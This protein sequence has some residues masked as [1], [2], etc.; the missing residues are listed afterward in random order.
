MDRSIHNTY[1]AILVPL[2]LVLLGTNQTR[3]LGVVLRAPRILIDRALDR[4]IRKLEIERDHL[5]GDLAMRIILLRGLPR[6]AP[7]V[8]TTV[9]SGRIRRIDLETRDPTASSAGSFFHRWGESTF[10]LTAIAA[11]AIIPP[12]A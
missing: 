4:T 7:A 2:I 1:I 9:M 10:G 8:T 5:P 3:T 12:P 6:S 11:R